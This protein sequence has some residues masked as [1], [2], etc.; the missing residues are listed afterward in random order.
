MSAEPVAVSKRRLGRIS[1]V[2]LKVGSG[3]IA[4]GGRL[5]KRVIEDLAYDVTVLRSQGVDVVMV[6]SGAVAAGFEPLGM[7]C[8]PTSVVQRQAAASVG[9]HRLMAMFANAFGRHRVQVAQLLMTAEDVEDRRRFLSARHTMQMLLR[10]GVV[11]IINE[12]DAISDD[13]SKVGDNDHLAALVTNL[14]SANLLV[15]L[16]RVEGLHRNGDKEV[17][18][19]VEVGSSVAEHVTAELSET[20]VGGMA[21]KVS[22]ANVAGQGGV[23]T[24]IAAGGRPGVLQRII[25]GEEIGTLFVPRDS[26][27]TARKRWIAVRS[28]SRGVIRVDGDAAKAVMQGASLMPAG[29]RRVHGRFEMGDRVEIKNARGRTIAVGLVSYRSDEIKRLQGKARTEYTDVLGYEYVKEIVDR[30]DMVLIR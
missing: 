5:R 9:Q 10:H 28:R 7:A 2:V 1:R 8:A 16:S 19:Q 4:G 24:V 3:V 23:P 21:A 22:A 30:D 18:P 12:N 20:G 15:I 6:V 13:E 25:A 17:I 27:L 26:R 14:S 11:P 29:I